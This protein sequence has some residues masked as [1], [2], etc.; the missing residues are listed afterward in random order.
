MEDRYM[1]EKKVLGFVFNEDLSQVLLK[2]VTAEGELQGLLNGIN[3]TA[4]GKDATYQKTMSDKLFEETGVLFSGGQMRDIGTINTPT[5]CIKVYYLKHHDLASIA[6]EHPELEIHPSMVM[7]QQ[8]GT[9]PL[10]S[11][12]MGHITI[13]DNQKD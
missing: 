10:L 13:S 1:I 5:G 6:D 9:A 3:A 12:I 11:S 7:H 4:E 8:N 2:T